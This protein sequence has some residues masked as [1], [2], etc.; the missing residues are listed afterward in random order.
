MNKPF[1]P[2][3]DHTDETSLSSAAAPDSQH[4]SLSSIFNDQVGVCA[5]CG[6]TMTTAKIATGDVVYYCPRDRISTPL[7]DN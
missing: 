7:A 6:G 2:L 4:A 5:V 1:N 3:T